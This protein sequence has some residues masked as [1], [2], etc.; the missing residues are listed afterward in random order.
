MNEAITFD[1]VLIIPKFSKVKSRKDLSLRSQVRV[2]G[3]INF[4]LNV[5]IIA[6]NMDTICEGKMASKM[7]DLGGCGILHRNMTHDRLKEDIK[8]LHDQNRMPIVAV[9]GIHTDKEKI[10]A[11]MHA[12]IVFCVDMAHGHS[13]NMK[14]TLEYICSQKSHPVIIAGNVCTPLGASELQEWGADIVKVG[15]GSGSVC[16]TRIKTGCGFPQL[17]AIMNIREQNWEV[18][19]IADGGLRTPGDCAKALAAGADF[20]M[21]GG[22]LAAT[23][24]TPG[25]IDGNIGQELPFRGM[26]SEGAK[27]HKTHVE[28]EE[29]FLKAKSRGST[30]AVILDVCDGI[31]SAMSYVG[32]STLDELRLKTEFVRVTN[33]VHVENQPHKVYDVE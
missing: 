31:K 17:Q 33:A 16:T 29:V 1:D 15:I 24:C 5:P 25:W 12:G 21:L 11:F 10:D 9:G 22:M 6:S 32:A 3:G 8:M 18:P 4:Y 26:A 14:D 19:I 30:E 28:G 27:G 2:N 23:D 13:Q 20:V 7:A